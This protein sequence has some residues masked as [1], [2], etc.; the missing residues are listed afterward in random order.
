MQQWY[1]EVGSSFRYHELRSTCYLR[2]EPIGMDPGLSAALCSLRVWFIE[3]R[4]LLR[5]GNAR[6]G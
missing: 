5:S 2:I 6:R 1:F 4:V 3:N